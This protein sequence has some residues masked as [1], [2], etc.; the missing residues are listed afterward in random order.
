MEH[1]VVQHDLKRIIE[2]F[3]QL[4]NRFLLCHYKFGSKKYEIENKYI[5][6]TFLLHN[7]VLNLIYCKI[8]FLKNNKNTIVSQN[9]NIYSFE[10]QSRISIKKDYT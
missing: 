6:I 5:I 7:S 4:M 8:F 10:N 3:C 2:S 9:Y 1:L